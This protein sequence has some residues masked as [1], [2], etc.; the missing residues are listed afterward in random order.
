M[1]DRKNLFWRSE[2]INF[3]NSLNKKQVSAL[4]WI[5][6]SYGPTRTGRAL[7]ED[8]ETLFSFYLTKEN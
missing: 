7:R 4:Y 2:V 6:K 3:A 8:I 5:L 1:T